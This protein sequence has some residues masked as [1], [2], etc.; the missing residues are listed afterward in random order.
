M[1][2]KGKQERIGKER[3]GDERVGEG[4]GEERRGEKVASQGT[5]ITSNFHLLRHLLPPS[6]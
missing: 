4:R 6:L 3:R 5:R 2:G 1:K